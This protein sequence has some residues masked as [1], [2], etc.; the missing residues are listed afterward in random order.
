MSLAKNINSFDWNPYILPIYFNYFNY[1]LSI[2]KVNFSRVAS[3]DVNFY[4]RDK[5][6]STNSV[7]TFVARVNT[8]K[9]G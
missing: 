1:I 8:N 4:F 3:I 5:I 7:P 2:I 9:L 6:E